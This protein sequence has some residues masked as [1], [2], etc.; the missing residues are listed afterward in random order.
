MCASIVFPLSDW[1]AAHLRFVG[2]VA[3]DPVTSLQRDGGLE[4]W[5]LG[6]ELL[7]SNNKI[8]LVMGENMSVLP[9]ILCLLQNIKR[10][11]IVYL[12][13]SMRQEECG[14]GDISVCNPLNKQKKV[15]MNKRSED[16]LKA[17]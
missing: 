6:V 5:L 2:P 16:A 13:K 12:S 10:Y 11:N 17:L 8:T 7:W 15:Y 3:R 9:K 4:A 1:H 14:R